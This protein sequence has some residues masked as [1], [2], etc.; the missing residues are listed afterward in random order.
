[1]SRGFDSYFGPPSQPINV[2]EFLQ[3]ANSVLLSGSFTN[4]SWEQL[5]PEHRNAVEAEITERCSSPHYTLLALI[6]HQRSISD[7]KSSLE[8]VW[9]NPIL[10]AHVLR[11]HESTVA[12]VCGQ[13]DAPATKGRKRKRQ[14]AP[15]GSESAPEVLQLQE[16][17]DAVNLRCWR[18]VS[19]SCMSLSAYLCAD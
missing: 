3:Q 9:D 10:S 6:A 16:K 17:L 5:T 2:A 18:Y 13:A 15:E 19:S 4:T 14:I 11:Q 8:Q 7:L 12:S 1:M